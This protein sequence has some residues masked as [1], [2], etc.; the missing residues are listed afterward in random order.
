[1]HERPVFLFGPYRLSPATRELLRDGEPIAVPA[2]VFDCI[3]YLVE[4]RARAVGRDELGAAVWGKVE[5][6]EAQLTQTILR[7]RRLLGD[8][9]GD[10]GVIRTVPRFGYHWTSAV[11]VENEQATT[12]AA[13]DP[14]LTEPESHAAPAQAPSP[15]HA[16]LAP[17][18]RFAWAVLALLVLTAAGAASLLL[19]TRTPAPASN[20]V[21]V[22]AHGALVLPVDAHD[23]GGHAWIR[24]G[25]VDVIADRLRA[26]GLPVPPTETTL[27]LLGA[28]AADT[29]S[30]LRGAG[31]QWVVN[32][33]ASRSAN[34]WRVVLQANDARDSQL[35]ASVEDADLL[36]AI[37]N[38]ADLLLRQMGLT[39]PAASGRNPAVDEVLQHARAA[40]LENDFE[41]AR[42]VL[43]GSATATI[44]EPELRYQLAVLA[45]RSGRLDEAEAQL[46]G[47]LDDE[48]GNTDRRRRSQ[49]HYTLGAIAMMRDHP[50]DA[51]QAFDQAL[52][53]LDRDRDLLDYG[54]ALGGRGGARLTLGR[55]Q[56]GFDD[57]GA[58]RTLLE[59]AGD[60][61]ALARMNLAFGIALLRRD[62][63]AEAIPVL[64]TALAQ[65]EP[66]GAINERAHG[67]S[68]LCNAQLERLDYAA[69]WQANESAWALLAH[70][71]NPLNRAET[72]LDRL[73]LLLDRGQFRAAVPL[74]AEVDALELGAYA[75]LDGRRDSL[76]AQHAWDRGDATETL[77]RTEAAI[78][79]L[80]TEDRD[81]SDRM[82]LLRQRALLALDRREQAAKPSAADDR[83]IDLQLA[84]A[85]LVAADGDSAAAGQAFAAA[86]ADAESRNLPAAIVRV[87]GSMIPYLLTHRRTDTASAILGRLTPLAG[88]DF[89]SALLRVRVHQAAGRLQAWTDALR[90][91]RSLAG[92]RTIPADL[93]VQPPLN[94]GLP[95]AR[96]EVSSLR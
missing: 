17:R 24:L 68:A 6:S 76:H 27:A 96:P 2:R 1:M 72:L 60:R 74:F 56:D 39:P 30:L 92:E 44:E 41:T 53:A 85:E 21:T 61:L 94:M 79:K 50:A 35:T 52:A 37:R 19:P 5:V 13:P 51:E 90:E 69:A 87:A 25:A 59:Q 15:P 58:A 20:S 16:T 88:Q 86:L 70:I 38:G 91:A 93:Q 42:R 73:A 45:F 83:S 47:L 54:K 71:G 82:V 89:D 81:A 36:T 49:I 8:D 63:A 95:A 7:V 14:E 12:P 67:Y 11:R 48:S 32:S 9:A 10:Q 43:T 75:S 29:N 34:G 46:H 3:T 18:P 84:R 22:A 64:T 66:F 4:H 62:Q 33:R 78:P 65:L 80:K 40:M 57:I 28:G 23:D 55:Q 26:A 77:A 31:T